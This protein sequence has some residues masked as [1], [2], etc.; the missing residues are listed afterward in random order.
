MVRKLANAPP[1]DPFTPPIKLCTLT[2]PAP[3]FFRETL[4]I[5]IP[6]PEVPPFGL[7]ALFAAE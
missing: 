6:W 5:M 7:K 1:I 4:G 3:F 2:Y